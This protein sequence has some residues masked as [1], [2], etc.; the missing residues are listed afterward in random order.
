MRYQVTQG[1]N[2][3][4][5]DAGF[6]RPGDIIELSGADITV[7]SASGKNS[8]GKFRRRGDSGIGYL[9]HAGDKATVAI[10]FSIDSMLGPRIRIFVST[11]PTLSDDTAGEWDAE[12]P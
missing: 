7:T 6:I 12:E 9:D 4:N 3:Q 1:M 2:Y 10:T 8:S 11:L 5:G